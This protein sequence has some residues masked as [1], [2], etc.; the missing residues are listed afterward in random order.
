L[1]T[2][3]GETSREEVS[4]FENEALIDDALQVDHRTGWCIEC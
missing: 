3:I 1:I 2:V 4:S